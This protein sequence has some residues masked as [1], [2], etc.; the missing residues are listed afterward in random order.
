MR[1]LTIKLLVTVMVLTLIGLPAMAADFT[2]KAG[3]GAQT[4][5]P[6]HFGLVQLA[7]IVQERSNGK[8]EIKVFPDRQLG[9]EREMV[10]GLQFGTVDMTVVSTGPLGGFVGEINVLDLP[11]LFKNRSH[12]YSVFDGPIGS[13]LLAKF[14][15]IGIKAVAIWENGWRHLTT[16]KPITSPADLKGLKMRTMANQIH[17]AAFK[18][19]GAGP[20]PMAWGEVYTSLDQGVI[21]AQENPIT[22]IYTNSLWEVQNYVTLT[23]HVYGPHLVLISQK[24]L[25]KLPEDLQQILISAAME[26]SSY[27]R[28]VGIELEAEQSLLLEQK[29]MKINT[30]DLE[31]F[32][33][34][35]RSSYKLFTDK[36]GDAMLMRI[37]TAGGRN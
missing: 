26:T 31:P 27:Q 21:E 3:H 28:Q 14:D 35:S 32:R 30:V 5:H 12:A 19:L 7:K 13:E 22:V 6:T 25:A 10:E 2:I 18:A 16:K 24:S 15:P 9:E 37:T 20:V 33:K 23:G 8:L 36:F 34:Q 1:H 29:G 11:F 17:M 4:G